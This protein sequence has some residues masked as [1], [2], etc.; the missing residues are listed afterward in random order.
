M[1]RDNTVRQAGGFIIQLMPFAEESVIAR[2]EENLSKVSSVTSILDEGHTPE[3]MLDILL[4]DLGVEITD[5]IPTR[6]HC[7]CTKKRVEKAIISIGKKDLQSMVDED[8][9]IDVNCHFCNTS[10]HFTVDELKDIL[11]VK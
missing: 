6:F 2:L 5:I 7:N 9:D 8:K 10:Y 11:K 3:E 1:N 4:G